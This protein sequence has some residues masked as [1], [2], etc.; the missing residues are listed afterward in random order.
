[1]KLRNGSLKA[2]GSV[3]VLALM[4]QLGACS[5][6]GKQSPLGA[7]DTSSLETKNERDSVGKKKLDAMT[8]DTSLGGI[9]IADEPTA[10]LLGRDILEKGGTAADAATAV[11]FALSVTYPASAGLGGGGICLARDGEKSD[12]RSISFPAVAPQSGGSV[13]VPGNVRGMAY[14]QASYGSLS[15]A[16][17]IAPSERLAATGF[18]ASRATVNQLTKNATTIGSSEVLKALYLNADGMAYNQGDTVRLPGLAGTLGRI[19]ASGVSGF[20]QGDTAELLIT[21]SKLNGGSITQND[22]TSY[23][24]DDAPAQGIKTGELTL[25]LP[26]ANIEAGVYA[27][28]L[29]SKVQNLS[30]AS[31]LADAAN[32]TAGVTGAAADADYGSTTFVAVDGL[33]GAVACAV[34]MNG[35]FGLGRVATGS[36][37]I[38]AATPASAIKGSAA[39]YLAPAML[40]REKSKNSLYVSAAGAGAPKA[41]AAVQSV[42]AAALTNEEGAPLAALA[43]GP[44]DALSTANAIVCPKGLPLGTCSI[45]VNPKG[46]GVGFSAAGQGS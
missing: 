30:G 10:A 2:I 36:G 14:L 22:L 38:F 43:N 18:Q 46:A 15:W 39:K 12:V 16:Q 34:S 11:Y 28:A 25:M 9:V 33:G 7:T 37:I 42:I 21:Q 5:G 4:A 13:A 23:R 3:A 31:A 41:V 26:A 44:A 17:V 45:N 8:S 32:Q 27:A 29:W 19:R 6:D 20:Y 40:V 1:M 24:P 35:A